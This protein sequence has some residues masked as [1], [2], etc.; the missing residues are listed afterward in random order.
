[1][2]PMD[3]W[4]GPCAACAQVGENPISDQKKN[5]SRALWCCVEVGAPSRAH[6]LWVGE[7]EGQSRVAAQRRVLLCA[8]AG[9]LRRSQKGSALPAPNDIRDFFLVARWKLLSRKLSS[10]FFLAT[11]SLALAKCLATQRKAKQALELVSATELDGGLLT[12]LLLLLSPCWRWRCRAKATCIPTL[13]RLQGSRRGGKKGRKKGRGSCIA[14]SSLPV[15]LAAPL[16]PPEGPHFPRQRTNERTS[17]GVS[18]PHALVNLSQSP[19]FWCP[20]LTAE[21]E[22]WFG[23]RRP[24]SPPYLLTIITSAFGITP[25]LHLAPSR[26]AT[27]RRR[28][29]AGSTATPTLQT[30]CNLV[31]KV[32][33]TLD[34]PVQSPS[35]LDFTT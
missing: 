10:I 4:D 26:S 30:T 2:P 18:I 7:K 21:A 14:I 20:T 6:F 3:G 27:H 5:G 28:H 33:L 19:L 22:L 8:A 11:R 24:P 1:M 17:S 31:V 15:F 25:S 23:R 35:C 16:V 32:S 12:L 9:G 29:I 34:L 13:V